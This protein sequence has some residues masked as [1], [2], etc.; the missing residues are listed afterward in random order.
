[1]EELPQGPSLTPAVAPALQDPG[2]QAAFQTP[3]W[4]RARLC[5]VAC[6]VLGV[7]DLIF[8][9]GFVVPRAFQAPRGA[10]TAGTTPVPSVISHAPG[11]VPA[12]RQERDE[13]PAGPDSAEAESAPT[14]AVAG[15]QSELP[16]G[17]IRFEIDSS[18]L[19]RDGQ[20]ALGR[21]L[22]RLQGDKDATLL[23]VG[24]TDEV[25]SDEYN[26]RLSTRRA[27]AVRAWL[28]KRGVSPN[29]LAIDG[30]GAHRPID[31]GGRWQ[32][33]ARNRRVEFFWK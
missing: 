32:A 7:V 19:S 29:R 18:D 21:V 3:A 23:I 15:A 13:A 20:E 27:E 22:A 9:N 31:R 11:L 1:M 30:V 5:L 33:R 6:V 4:G 17:R 16:S 24:H 25:G 28:V 14:R 12:G 2:S 8:L 10:E 26:D